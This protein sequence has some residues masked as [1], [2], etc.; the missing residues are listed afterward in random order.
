MFA[1]YRFSNIGK[2]LIKNINCIRYTILL[3]SF[4]ST[5]G[6]IHCLEAC[7]RRKHCN[8]IIMQSFLATSF[9]SYRIYCLQ[10]FYREYESPG[11]PWILVVFSCKRFH[12]SH[13]FSVNE[14]PASGCWHRANEACYFRQ[15]QGTSVHSGQST[16][17]L[18]QMR[19][20]VC[21]IMK[22]LFGKFNET[23]EWACLNLI[24]VKINIKVYFHTGFTL[25]VW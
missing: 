12:N 6:L 8:R 21:R 3:N 2:P 4:A 23:S 10:H 24:T 9:V 18:D 16:L 19:A 22:V 14:D 5:T 17:L 25:K 13:L 20:G 7:F 11:Q 1:S 15:C